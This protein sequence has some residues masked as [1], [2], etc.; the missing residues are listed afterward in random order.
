MGIT[1]RPRRQRAY[2]W[3]GQNDLSKPSSDRRLVFA[4]KLWTKTVAMLFDSLEDPLRTALMTQGIFS[5]NLIERGRRSPIDSRRIKQPILLFLLL[6]LLLILILFLDRIKVVSARAIN[7]D[8]III[9]SGK[10]AVGCDGRLCFVMR[11]LRPCFFV[12]DGCGCWCRESGSSASSTHPPSSRM[13]MTTMRVER[14][15]G[16]RGKGGRVAATDRPSKMAEW[17]QGKR[18]VQRSGS[19]QVSNAERRCTGRR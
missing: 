8:K 6:L 9:T 16:E 11:K 18:S 19:K 7:C 3:N 5:N 4:F 17:E 12:C 14:R 13:Q 1:N 2:D 15:E 10:S